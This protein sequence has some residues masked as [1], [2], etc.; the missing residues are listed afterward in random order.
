MTVPSLSE[1]LYMEDDIE[2]KLRIKAQ[3]QNALTRR[4]K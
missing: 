1:G 4:L 2:Y 3:S